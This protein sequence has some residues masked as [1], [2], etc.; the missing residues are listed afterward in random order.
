MAGPGGSRITLSA[1]S[2]NAAS[3]HPAH[4][5]LVLVGAPSGTSLAPDGMQLLVSHGAN[6]A[7]IASSAG[8][9]QRVAS[10]QQLSL[11]AEWSAGAVSGPPAP[12]SYTLIGRVFLG[13]GS[14]VEVTLPFSVS[15]G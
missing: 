4:L 3:G 6:Q 1:G 12:G 5:A 8:G 2:L 10:G 15:P 9:G 11:A 14:V 7:R 13:D